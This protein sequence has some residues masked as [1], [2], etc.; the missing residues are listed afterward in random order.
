MLQNRLSMSWLFKLDLITSFI[1]P[2][3][4]GVDCGLQSKQDVIKDSCEF[5]F[6]RSAISLTWLQ[7]RY[8]FNCLLMIFNLNLTSLT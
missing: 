8:V 1:C 6:L 2:S 7:S 5:S 4:K 3:I